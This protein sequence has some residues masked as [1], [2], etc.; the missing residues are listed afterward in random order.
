MVL[1]TVTTKTWGLT[2]SAT[3]APDDHFDIWCW[4]CSCVSSCAA[5]LHCEY[6]VLKVISAVLTTFITLHLII[7]HDSKKHSTQCCSSLP[8]VVH[9]FY[10]NILVLMLG[11]CTQYFKKVLEIFNFLADI[12]D[13]LIK[14][15]FLAYCSFWK[16]CKLT[17]SEWWWL[18]D[19][20]MC[21][22]HS[23][24][25]ISYSLKYCMFFFMI[26]LYEWILMESL[27]HLMDQF[28]SW[29]ALEN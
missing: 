20:I 25:I 29:S 18:S 10:L 22:L 8:W 12:N 4:K 9:A 5:A 17:G 27:H 24:S 16:C 6:A 15:T 13:A 11:F 28:K 1:Y 23:M 14:M 19:K 3:H 2:K 7:L 26:V 21:L